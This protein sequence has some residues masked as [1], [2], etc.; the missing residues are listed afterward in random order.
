M[1]D[2]AANARQGLE[3]PHRKP[4]I[5]VSAPSSATGGE[6]DD[7]AIAALMTA[8]LTMPGAG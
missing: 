1:R 7:A 8:R 4:C 5:M 2:P 3:R 6:T